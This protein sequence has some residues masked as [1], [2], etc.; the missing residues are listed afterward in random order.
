ME[1]KPCGVLLLDKPEGVSSNRALQMV[2][3]LLGR[4]KG[5]Y[6]GT[7]DPLAT[8]LLPICLGESTKY[9]SFFS[10]ATKTYEAIVQLGARSSTGDLEGTL[11]SAPISP[12][13]TFDTERLARQ[14]TG[15]LTQVPP[16]YSAVKVDGKRL[17]Q[18]ARAGEEIS[19]EPRA[20]KIFRLDITI[21]GPD[22]LKLDVVCSKGTYIRVLAE[23]ICE[24]S[25]NQG[26]LVALRRTAMGDVSVESAVMFDELSDMNNQ[27]RY[28][29]LG[30]V[31]RYIDCPKISLSEEAERQFIHGITVSIVELPEMSELLRI[32]THDQIFL[33]L[34]RALG[35]GSLKPK[36]LM[37]Q[38]YLS[39]QRRLN[40]YKD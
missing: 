37:S 11:A 29:V 5:G 6:A 31:D 3:G 23:D 8:G 15:L 28:R 40:S 38:E 9:L 26:H 25:G 36:R 22:R 20:I 34:G 33:G 24:A 39:N 35:D 21:L 7:L 32:Y 14:F 4:A 1:T 27:D 16:M 17:Y 10:E 18:L 19:R 13:T 12:L 2:R 30:N